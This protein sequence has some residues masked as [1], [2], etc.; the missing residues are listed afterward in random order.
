MVS[1]SV[2]EKKS[3][4]NYICAELAVE[5]GKYN[6]AVSRYYY[7]CYQILFNYV[8]MNNLITEAEIK[9]RDN[10][11]N[12]EKVIN[13]FIDDFKKPE[14]AEIYQQCG[15]ALNQIKDLKRHRKIA[16]Y[17]IA[18][19]CCDMKHPK[20]TYANSRQIAKLLRET[21]VQIGIRLKDGELNV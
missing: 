14:K 2:L 8:V 18:I 9:D 7:S 20:K 4:E 6:A 13:T 21:F 11:I 1:M 10:P 12:H 17:D 3:E 5:H 15:Y 16:D 19:D